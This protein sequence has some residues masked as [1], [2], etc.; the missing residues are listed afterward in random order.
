MN[1]ASLVHQYYD[2]FMAR[3]GDTLLPDQRKALDAILRC[4]TPAAGELYAQCPDC[5]HGQWRPLSCG[6]RHCPQ[7][8]N[9]LTSLWIDKQQEKLL[10]VSYFMVTFTLPYQLRPLAYARQK[11]VY[12]L[13]FHCAA[14]VLRTFARNAK[15]LGAEI[16]MTMVLHT[17]SRR[18]EY[19]PHIHV[20]IPGGGIDRQNRVWKKVSGKY[21][22]NSFAL[23]KAFRGKFLA[24]AARV[25]LRVAGKVPKKWVAHCDHMG[26]GAPALK[27][28]SR[29]LYRGVI[30]EKNIIANTGGE[31]TFRYWDRSTK[32]MLKRKLKGEEFLSLLLKHV[33]P[34]GF[35]RLREY[36]FLHGN[37]KKIRMLVQLV[38]HVIL[39][40]QPPRPRP[41]F[42][43]PHC[44]R[45]MRIMQFR[46]EYRQPG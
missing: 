30:G 21:L 1:L 7:C 9:H 41:V 28:L 37:A 36:G 40:P 14:E 46:N 2:T 3:Y 29:Y 11:E 13:M 23:A 39:R 35:R 33:L 17:H 18:L 10:P 25:G 4:R 27:Y 42:V 6:N 38:L 12:S 34:N 44:N 24:E 8:Q 22:F 15:H 43:C 26:T 31:V 16:G 45:P 19:H 32:T 5:H 20:L